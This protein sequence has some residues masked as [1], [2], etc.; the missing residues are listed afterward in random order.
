MLVLKAMEKRWGLAEREAHLR[1]RA[2]ARYLPGA[3]HEVLAEGLLTEHR[4]RAR[5]EVGL[6]ILPTLSPG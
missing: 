6:N 5:I 3:E 4:L 2:F 1:L